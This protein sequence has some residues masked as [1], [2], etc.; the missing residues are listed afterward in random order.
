MESTLKFIGKIH[1]D[2]KRLEDC[3]RQEAEGAPEASLEIFPE[4]LE[5]IKDIRKGSELVLLT[6]FHKSDRNEIKTRPRNDPNAS[7]IGIFSTRSPNRP[8]PIGMHVVKVISVRNNLIKID[9]LEAL[10]QTPLID[11]KPKL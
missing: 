8:N 7:L 10:D 2:L 4:F 11:I 6:W 5:G 9:A 1:S 3:P